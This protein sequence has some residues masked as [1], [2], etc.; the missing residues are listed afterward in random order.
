MTFEWEEITDEVLEKV[1]F[2]A[3]RK[4]ELLI[5]I[6]EN[7]QEFRVE[8]INSVTRETAQ[9]VLERFLGENEFKMLDEPKRSG[10][11]ERRPSFSRLYIRKDFTESLAPVI[12]GSE[13]SPAEAVRRLLD[14]QDRHPRINIQQ[15]L[16]GWEPLAMDWQSIKEIEAILKEIDQKLAENKQRL[17][18]ESIPFDEFRRRITESI[19]SLKQKNGR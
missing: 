8:F 12:E 3:L 19:E 17:F 4:R 18:E 2:V 11:N 16:E 7:G 10:Q 6:T 15:Q 14:P 9:E 13:I 1:V 5:A